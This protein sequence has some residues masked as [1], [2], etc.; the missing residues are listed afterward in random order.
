MHSTGH[1]LRLSRAQDAARRSVE[2][3][4][5]SS[6]KRKAENPVEREDEE[7]DDGKRVRFA[8]VK[9][10]GDAQV[11]V[12]NVAPEIEVA[13]P[14]GYV[15]FDAQLAALDADL[16]QMEREAQYESAT[17]SAPAL[18]AE[19]IAAQAREEISAQRGRRDVEIADEK[20]EA[21]A[22]LQEEFAEMEE[23]EER[24]QRLR[25]RRE[26]LRKGVTGVAVGNGDGAD[27]VLQDR[28]DPD[29]ASGDSKLS[30]TDPESGGDAQDDDE[31]DEED[32][33]EWAFGAR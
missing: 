3:E 32:P 16:A 11:G 27:V 33:D 10:S 24:V 31:E 25:E 26:R 5:A 19:E 18:T 7:A 17:I 1:T 28:G 6:R 9:G 8:D 4:A 23:L 29:S 20:E 12:E 13:Q 21:V 14:A 22:R 2:T 30:R 15:D